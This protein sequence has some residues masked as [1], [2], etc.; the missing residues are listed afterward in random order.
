HPAA[1]EFVAQRPQQEIGIGCGHD[2]GVASTVVLLHGFTQT[3]ASWERV[4]AML[5]ERYRPLA[6]DIRGHGAASEL[7][8]VTLEGVIEDVSAGVSGPFVLVGYSMGGRIGLHAA[9]A[10]GDRVARLVLIGASPGIADS[11]QRAQ[12]R[13]EDERL[14]DELE[15]LPID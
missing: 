4:A 12:R 10:L 11:A 13:A 9:L 5:P 2:G 14:A 7:E 8:P 3:G 1:S 6:P 15:A